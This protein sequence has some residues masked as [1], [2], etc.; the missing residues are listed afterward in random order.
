MLL[1]HD[2]ASNN[3]NNFHLFCLDLAIVKT[4][5]YQQSTLHYWLIMLISS[6]QVYFSGLVEWLQYK[7]WF[8]FQD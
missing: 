7:K 2:Y 3:D 5:S 8:N 4:N 1:P 6:L